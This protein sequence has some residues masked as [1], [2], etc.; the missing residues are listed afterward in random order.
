M[1]IEQANIN[2]TD[3]I[4]DFM[5][6]VWKKNHILSQHKELFLHEFQ[7]EEKLNFIVARDNDKIVGIFGFIK[8]NSSQLP[9]IAGSLWKVDP[10]VK[11]PL[12]GL[13]MRDYFTKNIPHRFYAAPGAGLQ[14][15]DIYKV[16][17][18]NW[19]KMDQFYITNDTIRTFHIAKNPKKGAISHKNTPNVEIKK[20]K[21]I[22]EIATFDFSQGDIVPQKDITYIKKRFIDFPIYDYDIY[23]VTD[24]KRI[25]N[26]FVCRDIAVKRSHI[27]RVVDFLGPLDY[28]ADIASFL[29]QYILKQNYEYVDFVSYGFDKELLLESGF[30]LV[31]FA[32]D[33][34]IIPNYF[35]PFLQK[36][37]PIYCVWNH[38]Q[39][40]FRQCKADGDQDRPNSF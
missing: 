37:V 15:R 9:D 26:I 22:D 31:D 10:R 25:I 38:T 6:K 36:N 28:I 24:A 16:I 13:K 30:H 33:S 34:V 12:L 27:Y 11:T 17:K 8:Y 18:M 23:Y 29:Y 2:D 32:S 5:D 4:M 7:E 39:M 21:H 35:E 1:L 20:L 3:K 40:H 14:T 19:G